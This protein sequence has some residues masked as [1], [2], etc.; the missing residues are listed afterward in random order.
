MNKELIFLPKLVTDVPDCH[1]SLMV[2]EALTS[3]STFA[4]MMEL[5]ATEICGG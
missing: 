4:F 1:I 5:G 3:A 2:A